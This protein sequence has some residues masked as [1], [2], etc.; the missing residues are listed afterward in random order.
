M[1][2]P[3]NPHVNCRLAN[4]ERRK[5]YETTVLRFS[6][7]AGRRDKPVALAA[8]SIARKLQ[9]EQAQCFSNLFY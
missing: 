7:R 1:W 4:L 5:T 2:L 8:L 6:H 3:S 9:T